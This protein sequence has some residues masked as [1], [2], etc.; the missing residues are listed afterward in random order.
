MDAHAAGHDTNKRGEDTTATRKQQQHHQTAAASPYGSS[1]NSNLAGMGAGSNPPSTNPANNVMPSVQDMLSMLGNFC[2]PNSDGLPCMNPAA[3]AM[4]KASGLISGKRPFAEGMDQPPAKRHNF[5]Q[6][7]G[8]AN[9]QPQSSGPSGLIPPSTEGIKFYSRNDV[10]CGRGGGTNVHPGNRRFRD[11]INANRRAYL[12]ARKND[13]PNISRSIVRTV[14]EMNGRFLKKDDKLGLWFEIGD[15]GARE[16][17]SQALR[18]RAPEMRKILMEDEQRQTQEQ[19]RSRMMMQMGGTP[20]MDNSMPSNLGM[21]NNMTMNPNFRNQQNSMPSM[22]NQFMMN[23]MMMNN[24]RMNMMGGSGNTD[25]MQHPNMNFQSQNSNGSSHSNQPSVVSSLRGPSQESAEPQ[26]QQ[27]SN[28]SSYGGGDF[29]SRYQS[30]INQKNLLQEKHDFLSRLAMAGID[31]ALIGR[32]S[33]SIEEMQKQSSRNKAQRLSSRSICSKKYCFPPDWPFVLTMSSVSGENLS[34]TNGD[35][36]EDANKQANGNADKRKR[37]FG[38]IGNHHKR[39][40]NR[41]GMIDCGFDEE[42]FRK[43]QQ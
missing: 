29:M 18:Q 30:L 4:A 19:L 41:R 16:K 6:N 39:Q 7:M 13:K 9:Q 10:L 14:R 35:G 3:N 42:G 31:P 38:T 12:K 40:G 22:P 15:D 24:M 11:L 32:Q 2:P 20:N 21:N 33:A 34:R 17:T 28:P 25:G 5:G 23:Q 1:F 36:R 8:C 26:Q 27:V 43:R 37:T